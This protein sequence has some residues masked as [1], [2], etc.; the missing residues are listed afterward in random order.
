MSRARTPTLLAASLAAAL[1]LGACDGGREQAP[2][3][4]GPEFFAAA[5]EG[6]DRVQDLVRQEVLATCDKWHHPGEAACDAEQVRRDQL[7]CWID[8][9]A[10]LQKYVEARQWRPRQRAQRLLLE[11]NVCMEQ[12]GWRKLTPGRD[13]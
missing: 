6:L 3:A 4:R 5:L 13:F 7:E 12:R 11:V 2:A 1:L 8:K 10:P 9:G